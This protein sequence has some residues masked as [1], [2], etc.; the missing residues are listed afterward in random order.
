M[1]GSVGGAPPFPM[2]AAGTNITVDLTETH[3]HGNSHLDRRDG[4]M[5]RKEYSWEIREKAEE[6]YVYEGLTFGEV[7]LK[8]GVSETQLKRWAEQGNWGECRK[9]RRKALSDL[10]LKKFQIHQKLIE[11]ALDTLDSRAIT[12][13]CRWMKT[14]MTTE[15]ARQSKARVGDAD[16]P[17]LFLE[18]LEFI[19]MVLKDVD[20]KGLKAIAGNYDTIVERFKAEYMNKK[21]SGHL[22]PMGAE[23]T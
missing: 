17:L 8:T 11:N 6:L 4:I 20:Q 12:A 19:C 7:Y 5:A 2:S 15:T 10:K 14:E 23:G 3:T 13:A 16:S 18:H 21:Y 1:S 9:E 22:G